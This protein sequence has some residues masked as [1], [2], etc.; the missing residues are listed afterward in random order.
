MNTIILYLFSGRIHLMVN[1]LPPPHDNAY[2]LSVLACGLQAQ[3]G[4][5][6]SIEPGS[7]FWGTTWVNIKPCKRCFPKGRPDVP[8]EEIGN[9]QT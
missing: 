9:A 7:L 4:S 8:S 5:S 6:I 2:P 1:E 3:K